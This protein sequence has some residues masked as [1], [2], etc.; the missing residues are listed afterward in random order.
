[1]G[2]QGSVFEP[3][4]LFIIYEND[5]DEKVKTKLYKFAGDTKVIEKV[6][7]RYTSGCGQI[8]SKSLKTV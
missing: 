6:Q 8:T 4:I 1:V 3:I 7:S 5:M 2:Y